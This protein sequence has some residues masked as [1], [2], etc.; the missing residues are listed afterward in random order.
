MISFAHRASATT[1]MAG[2]AP[3]HEQA[4]I[5]LSQASVAWMERER[6]PGTSGQSLNVPF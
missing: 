4:I 6:N 2:H 1:M 5:N 3:N